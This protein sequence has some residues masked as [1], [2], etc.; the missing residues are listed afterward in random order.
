MTCIIRGEANE[1]YFGE[2]YPALDGE[3]TNVATSRADATCL[4]GFETFTI[5]TSTRAITL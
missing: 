3:H 4:V 5:P 2:S 1:W